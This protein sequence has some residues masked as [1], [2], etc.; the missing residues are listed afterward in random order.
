MPK[1][2]LL[3]NY[4]L[5]YYINGILINLVLR[6]NVMSR[7][8]PTCSVLTLPDINSD[9]FFY[10]SRSWQLLPLANVGVTVVTVGWQHDVYV[11]KVFATMIPGGH[12][13]G[14]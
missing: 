4:T 2:K 13:S 3:Y 10:W 6:I 7:C 14:N 8:P 12:P 1:M 5:Y 11:F 9:S